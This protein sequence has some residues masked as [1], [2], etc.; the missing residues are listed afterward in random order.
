M[1]SCS[2]VGIAGLTLGGGYGP[3][4]RFGLAQDPLSDTDTL[5]WRHRRRDPDPREQLP[6][7]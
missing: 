3:L 1:G 4:I 7:N 6:E 2:G 5:D